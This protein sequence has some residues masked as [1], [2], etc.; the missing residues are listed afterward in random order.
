LPAIYPTERD[1]RRGSAPAPSDVERLYTFS[2]QLLVTENVLELLK[3]IPH[4]MAETFGVRMQQFT[5]R[6]RPNLSFDP[7]SWKFLPTNSETRRRG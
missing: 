4:F 6:Q 1:G 5:F 7:T 3:S 2:Q